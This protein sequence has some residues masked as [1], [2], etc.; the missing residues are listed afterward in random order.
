[1]I[2]K[3]LSEKHVMNCHQEQNPNSHSVRLPVLKE[4]QVSMEL[5]DARVEL[6]LLESEDH[7]AVLVLQGNLVNRDTLGHQGKLEDKD[8]KELQ[9]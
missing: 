7:Q 1:M 8:H 5:R 9:V 3:V 2:Q 4:C 6:V